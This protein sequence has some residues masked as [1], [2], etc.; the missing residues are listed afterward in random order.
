[1]AFF[2]G[3]LS[4]DLVEARNLPDADTVFFNIANK[5]VSDPFAQVKLGHCVICKTAYINN[6]LSPKWQESFRVPVCHEVSRLRVMVLDKDH[7]TDEKLGQVEIDPQPLLDGEVIEGWH[8]LD[9]CEGEVYF[10]LHVQRRNFP[11]LRGT[12]LLL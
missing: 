4:V 6:N 10:K 11:R 2:R 1:M 9:G 3:Y 7:L 8:P 5:D 12:R